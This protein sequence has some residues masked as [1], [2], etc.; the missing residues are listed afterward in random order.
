MSINRNSVRN[1]RGVLIEYANVIKPLVL[2]FTF[3]PSSITRTRSVTVK[4]GGAPGTRGGY[5]FR[6]PSE[7]PRASQ[8]VSVEAES[9]SLKILL[10][11]T[12]RMNE[13]ND[14]RVT[15]FGVQ[16]EI[17]TIRMML[18]P[19]PQ[20]PEGVQILSAIGQG[21]QRAFSRHEFA[22]VLL[23]KWGF[24]VLPV[25]MTSA[26]I[27]LKEFLP[28]LYPY[29]AEAALTLQVIE[30]ENPIYSAE[31]KRQI[32]SA[33]SNVDLEGTLPEIFKP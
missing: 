3:N 12:D 30:S 31:K 20:M 25:F 22:S 10:D 14:P 18:E 7:T 2:H 27:E 29:R 26:Q 13:K 5:D 9:F 19:K 4:T 6:S 16:P 1:E 8:G 28:N 17:D 15:L 33:A 21:E 32:F 23:F 24:Q 11:A